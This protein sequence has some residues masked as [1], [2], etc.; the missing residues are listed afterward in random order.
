MLP[1]TNIYAPKCNYLSGAAELIYEFQVPT[2]D[3]TDDFVGY[4]FQS[5]G[6]FS[7]D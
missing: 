7:S 3:S 1:G 2:T 4:L 5:T 6:A